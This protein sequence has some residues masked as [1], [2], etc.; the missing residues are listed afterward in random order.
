MEANSRGSAALRTAYQAAAEEQRWSKM[1]REN[2]TVLRS[3]TVPDAACIQPQIL[4]TVEVLRRKKR[5]KQPM[6]ETISI[7]DIPMRKEA[8]LKA[9]EGISANSVKVP[10]QASSLAMPSPV[11]KWKRPK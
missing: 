5:L 1:C 4:Y 3:A 11:Q 9:V 7:M 10:S 6:Q 2:A 8:A